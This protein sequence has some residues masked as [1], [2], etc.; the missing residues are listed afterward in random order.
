MGVGGLHFF[1]NSKEFGPSELATM[2]CNL[3]TA[4]NARPWGRCRLPQWTSA[5]V[6]HYV[7]EEQVRAHRY[8]C[9]TI[10]LLGQ[11]H[12]FADAMPFFNAPFREFIA[13]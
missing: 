12:F 4:S 5:C 9:R 8:R 2:F 7:F 10:L 11:T 3:H 13:V 6:V 1:P